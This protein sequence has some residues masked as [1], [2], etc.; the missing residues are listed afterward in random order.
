[1]E[2]E[3]KEITVTIPTFFFTFSDI[4]RADM[5]YFGAYIC[6]LTAKAEQGELRIFEAEEKEPKKVFVGPEAW[7]MFYN[8]ATFDYLIGSALYLYDDADDLNIEHLS[9][10]EF[11]T[12]I[13]EYPDC[14]RH[15]KALDRFISLLR[16]ARQGDRETRRKNIDALKDFLIPKHTGGR[17]F[18][19]SSI[20]GA[21]LLVKGLSEHIAEKCRAYLKDYDLMTERTIR[22]SD[23]WYDTLIEWAK[24]SE[25]RI[26]EMDFDELSFLLLSPS[27]YAD[28][29]L[30]GALDISRRTLAAYTSLDAM[31][32]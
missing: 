4:N 3:E 7:S 31:S 5:R 11:L 19:P 9:D 8:N 16:D 26:A 23:V 12:Q 10:K 14:L 13:Q 17:A 32:S 15:E 29:R 21:R 28:S 22:Y 20:R 24:E 30:C 1:M 6:D 2:M 27:E 25:K 18:I